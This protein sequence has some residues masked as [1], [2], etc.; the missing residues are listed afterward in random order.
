ELEL[1]QPRGRSWS[2]G[3]SARSLPRPLNPSKADISRACV[4]DRKE[5]CGPCV[6]LA[7][8]HGCKSDACG[9]CHMREAAGIERRPRQATRHK[10]KEKARLLMENLE[11]PDKR[12]EL[13]GIAGHSLYM[14]SVVL[15]MI[16]ASG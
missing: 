16:H 5:T 12:K 11:D 15:S 6:F 13:Q 1:R 14:R 3:P 7:S 10:L 4:K 9:F 8:R 2:E